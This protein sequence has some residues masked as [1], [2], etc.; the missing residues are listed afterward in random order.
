[1]QRLDHPVV[2]VSWLDATAYAA[3]LARV[4]GLPWRLPTEAEWEWA[5]R[6]EEGRLYPWG[7]QWDPARAN[8]S[9][10]GKGGT[11]PVGAYAGRGDASPCGAHDMAGNEWEW[12]SSAWQQYPNDDRRGS[13]QVDSTKN[14]VLRGGSWYFNARI[15]RVA[16]RG[17]RGLGGFRLVCAVPSS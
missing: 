3:W 8:T 5:A 2:K 16:F 17:S 7:D 1:L 11:T 13:N 15:A 14:R 12:T 9:E 6:G 10:G 4:T